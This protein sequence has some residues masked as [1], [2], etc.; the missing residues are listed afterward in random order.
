[1]AKFYLA[2][3]S[4]NALLVI[5]IGAFGSHGLKAKLTV[6]NMAIYQTAVQYHFYHAVG[7]ILV[8][9]IAWHIPNSNYLRWSAWLMVMGIVLFCG[10]LYTLSITNIRWLG[11]I[12]PFGGMAFILAWLF[13]SI[14]IIK[15]ST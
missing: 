12:T 3:G 5:I 15:S 14:G 2:L 10:S 13:L 8:G 4:I 11:M 7:L 9:L 1:M 6:D